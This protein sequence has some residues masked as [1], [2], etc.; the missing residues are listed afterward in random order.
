M[1]T[2]T[3]YIPIYSGLAGTL[4]EEAGL[5]G[6][7]VHWRQIKSLLDD[8]F[9]QRGS[10]KRMEK[11]FDLGVG[12]VAAVPF[13][14]QE[15]RGLVLYYA[16]STAKT[17][18]LRAPSNERYMK[19]SADLIGANICIRKARQESAN[20]RKSMF[21]EAV[22]KAKTELLGKDSKS[23]FASMILNEEDMKKLKLE[24]DH[25]QDEDELH[26]PRVDRFCVKMGKMV[27]KF[28]KKA[29]KR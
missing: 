7:K 29:V 2:L 1:L 15:Q 28:G 17:E 22:R 18:L 4:A 9:V 19:A 6:D 10:G 16:R 23:G 21:K 11:L 20:F 26:L 27:I 25:A 3:H 13:Q 24:R 14:S 8:P 12:I 5:G